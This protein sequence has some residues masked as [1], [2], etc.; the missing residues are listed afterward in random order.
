MKFCCHSQLFKMGTM[1]QICNLTV[2]LM[3]RHTGICLGGTKCLTWLTLATA[4]DEAKTAFLLLWLGET[5]QFLLVVVVVQVPFHGISL[6]SLPSISR[7]MDV[8]LPKIFN[9]VLYKSCSDTARQISWSNY[10]L[11]SQGGFF[12]PS[13]EIPLAF[14]E[15]LTNTRLKYTHMSLSI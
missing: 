3:C 8:V 11:T 2:V 4:A 15:H 12:C 6:P 10:I 14:L 1:P 13:S 7:K 9:L 5:L